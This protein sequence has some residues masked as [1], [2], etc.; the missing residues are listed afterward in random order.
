MFI[1]VLVII[2]II[3]IIIIIARERNAIVFDGKRAEKR[4]IFK[5][6][7]AAKL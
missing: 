7:S 5:I 6:F 3:I 4:Y 2:I 1:L